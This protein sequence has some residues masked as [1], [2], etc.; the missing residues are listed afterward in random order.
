MDFNI[1]FMFQA[2]ME[3]GTAIPRSLAIAFS[4]VFLGAFL[5]MSIALARF[6]RV[7]AAGRIAQGVI[8]ITKGL[9]IILVYFMLFTLLAQ[10]GNMPVEIITL[11][12]ITI[13][14][15]TE[16]SEAFRGA[17]ESV[18]KSQFD[19]AFSIGH[20]GTHTFFRIVLPQT[21]PVCVPVMGGVVIH[22]IKALPVAGMIGLQDI[23]STANS[24]SVINYRYLESYIAA[25][26]IFWAIF[27]IVEKIF[28]VI[29]NKFKQVKV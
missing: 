23:L 1:P 5:G 14:T 8:T 15:S 18:E 16:M 10:N 27:I 4:A 9:P 19:A 2:M 28:S 12:G 25:A 21:I 26:L 6:Y 7:P 11:L 3:A 29:E 13:G 24:A 20:S 17:L 22:A